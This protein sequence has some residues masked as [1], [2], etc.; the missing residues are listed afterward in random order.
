MAYVDVQLPIPV[1]SP[2]IEVSPL[3]QNIRIQ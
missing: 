3:E 2:T 1:H